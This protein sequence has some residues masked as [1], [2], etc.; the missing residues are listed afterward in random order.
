MLHELTEKVMEAESTREYE[1]AVRELSEYL[2]SIGRPRQAQELMEISALRKNKFSKREAEKELSAGKTAV[3]LFCRTFQEK[4]DIHTMD[5]ICRMLDN[6]P[7][8]CR[9]LYITEMHR[10]CSS[11][12]K[13]HLSGFSIENEYDLQKLM[14]A[15]FSLVFPDARVESIQDSGHHAVRRDIVIDSQSAVIELKCSR[16][17]MTERQL[18]EEIASDMIHY[19]CSALYFYIYDK[20]GIISNAASFKQTYEAK[21]IDRKVIKIS[22][23]S[24]AD[25]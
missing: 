24:H 17:G 25:I 22:I 20:A 6:F 2:Y 14:L 3:K 5:M 11:G 4:N 12:F 13:E 15:A 21:S 23:Y 7:A 8:F 10:K 1:Q 16:K 19:E 18:S 9:K